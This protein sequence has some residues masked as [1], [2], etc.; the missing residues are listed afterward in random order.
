MAF[1][2]DSVA[3]DSGMSAGVQ[4]WLTVLFSPSQVVQA[5]R[6]KQIWKGGI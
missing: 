3:E 2:K 6:K 4:L 5:G 1:K